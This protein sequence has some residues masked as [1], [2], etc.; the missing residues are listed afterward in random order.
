MVSRMLFVLSS[1]LGTCAESKEM[2][3]SRGPSREK[4]VNLRVLVVF[5]VRLD[6]RAGR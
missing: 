3:T 6:R 2:S 5:A 4:V 1:L